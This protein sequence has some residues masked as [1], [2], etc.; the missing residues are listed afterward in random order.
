L[1]PCP[2]LEDVFAALTD[3]RA[4]DAVVPVQNSPR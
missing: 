4:S 1:L 3:R 2:T